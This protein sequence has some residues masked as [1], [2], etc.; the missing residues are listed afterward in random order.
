LQKLIG[1]GYSDLKKP[2]LITPGLSV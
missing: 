2:F 1:N